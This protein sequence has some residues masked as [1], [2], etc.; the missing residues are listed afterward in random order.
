MRT[1]RQRTKRIPLGDRDVLTVDGISE[2]DR[3]A[4]V[5]RWVND[6]GDRIQKL[7]DAGYDFVG[8]DG[9]VAGDPNVDAA[10]GV[11]SVLSK[12]VGGGITAYLMRQPR[13]IWEAD[14]KK[15][16]DDKTDELEAA[17]KNPRQPG[18]Y[19]GIEVNNVKPK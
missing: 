10:K 6:T 12:G 1:L 17:M 7:Y 13:E 14:R 3:K 11:S 16:V 8:K 5:Y 18:Q 2:A 15:R 19:G 9:K 4:Y